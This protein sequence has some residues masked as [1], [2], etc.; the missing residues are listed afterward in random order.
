MTHP[1][2]KSSLSA[3]QQRLVELCQAVNFGR[4]EALRIRNGVPSFDPRPRVVQT[5]K[6]GGQNGARDEAILPDF[7]LKSSLVEL[8]E[9][10]KEIGDGEILSIDVKHGL[11]FTVEIE[12]PEVPSRA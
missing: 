5:I 2:S 11:P 3:P 1:I 10:I 8:L 4:I 6:L 7:W 12:R 9:T